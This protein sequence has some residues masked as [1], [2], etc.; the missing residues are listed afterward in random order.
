[1]TIV[2]RPNVGKSTLLNRLVGRKL[3]ITSPKPQTTRNRITGV[4]NRDRAQIVFIDTPGIHRPKHKLGEYMVGVAMAALE[5]VEAILFVVEAPEPPGPGDRY[6]AE[7]LSRVRTPVLLVV[8]KA[9]LCPGDVTRANVE[10]YLKLGEFAG[11][12]AISAVRDESFEL[13]LRTIESLLPEGP[14]YYPEGI[15]TDQ[16]EAFVIAEL[17]REKVLETTR[18]EVPHSVAVVVEELRPGGRRA[19]VAEDQAGDP[20]GGQLADQRE[21]Q[22]E[23]PR[24][25]PL[26]DAP[27]LVYARAVIYVERESQKGIIVGS[28]GTMLRDVG[29]RARREIEALFGTK[30]YLDLWVKVEKNWRDRAGVLRALG[31]ASQR[32]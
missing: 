29:R 27:D 30:V 28:G 25:G 20:R 23:A 17:V 4:V 8:N 32:E 1:M 3:A 14:R 5:E 9:D 11:H 7:R 2:G 31:Y 21:D 15:D 16:P 12:L 24:A 13:L 22:R 19:G 6:V 18:D 10:S 26:G